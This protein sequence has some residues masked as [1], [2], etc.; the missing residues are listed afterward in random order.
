MSGDPHAHWHIGCSG[1]SYRHWR[2]T[3]Y[4]ADV[5]AR[6]WLTHYASQFDTVELNNSFYHLPAA[7]AIAGWVGAIPPGVRFSVKASRLITHNKRLANSEELLRNFFARVR[8]F[9]DRLGPV[10]YQLP[11]TFLR[12]E[13]RLAAFLDLLPADLVH[14][15]EFR[16]ESWWHP[17]VYALLRRHRAAFCIYSLGAQA[18]PVIATSAH[19]VEAHRR[20]NGASALWGAEVGG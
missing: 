9:G 16:H 19:V 3:Y 12:D 11:P 18:S 15:F 13:A 10:L 7:D 8:L 1:W 5:P 14:A 4:P 6:R 20:A 2:R 17:D